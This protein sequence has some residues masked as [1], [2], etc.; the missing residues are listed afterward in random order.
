MGQL[1]RKQSKTGLKKKFLKN[2]FHHQI[3]NTVGQNQMKKLLKNEDRKRKNKK[4]K[5]LR[6]AA[7][8]LK[9][10]I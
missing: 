7:K 3:W 1:K 8:N 5:Q 4:K 2:L 10:R 6:E 9:L